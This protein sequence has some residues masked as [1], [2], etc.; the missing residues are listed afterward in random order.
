M[1]KKKKPRTH[2]PIKPCAFTTM[3]TNKNAMAEETDTPQCQRCRSTLSAMHAAKAHMHN[4]TYRARSPAAL[5]KT[6]HFGGVMPPASLD[7]E[8]VVMIVYRSLVP[9]W[10]SFAPAPLAPRLAYIFFL[11]PTHNEQIMHRTYSELNDDSVARTDMRSP[12]VLMH[13][14]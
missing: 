8:T 9:C 4:K 5:N 2:A 6:A 3:T 1:Q 7:D 10:S 14:T 11:P 12:S 13:A